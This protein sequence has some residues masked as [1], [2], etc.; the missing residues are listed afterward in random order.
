MKRTVSVWGA[1]ALCLALGLSGCSRQTAGEPALQEREPAANYD[2]PLTVLTIGTA[3]SGGTMYPVGSAIA[4]V[5]SS[6]DPSIKVNISASNGSFSNVEG[7]AE[8]QIDLGLVSG[9]VAYYASTGTGGFEEN[10]VPELCAI[11]A[12]YP[13]VSNWMALDESDLTY[14][15]DLAG[16]RASVGPEDSATEL[17]ARIS[18]SALGITDDNASLANWGLGSGA[19]AVQNRQIDAVHGFAGT[20]ISGLEDLASASP[21]H[22]LKYTSEELDTIVASSPFYFKTVIPAGTYT[23]QTEDVDTF[24]IKCLLCVRADMDEELVYHITQ[25]IRES[26]ETLA[27]SHPALRALTQEDFLCQE[28]PIRLHP[29]AAR[30]YEDVGFLE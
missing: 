30:Y 28:L 19:Q 12:V 22:L 8:G 18:L 20:P 17:A 10:P 16:G 21:S 7:I 26:T 23:G 3:D 2:E 27:E 9:D 6:C 29:G 14:V 1:M 15:H 13:S 25:I 24:G 5:I 11:G 4:E